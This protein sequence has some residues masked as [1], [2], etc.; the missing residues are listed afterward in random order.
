MEKSYENQIQSWQQEKE[1][2]MRS[3]FGWLSIRG[4][5]WLK[6]GT[7]LFGT[8]PSLPIVL[9]KKTAPAHAGQF[10]LKN[11]QMFLIPNPGIE[12]IVNSQKPT[13]RQLIQ[14]GHDDIRLG[15]LKLE[16]IQRDN[17][18][19]VRV[20]DGKSPLLKK[21][22]RRTWFPIQKKWRLM[23]KLIT[24]DNNQKLVTTNVL[25]DT[26][27]WDKAQ[28][29]VFSHGSQEYRLLSTLE[30]TGYLFIL[31]KDLSSKT[32]TYPAG[33]FLWAKPTPDGSVILDFNKAV[34]PPCAVTSYATCPLPPKENYL[35][36]V[37]SAGEKYAK[38][39]I[40]H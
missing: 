13:N 12:F 16:V 30:D 33:R 20:R 24:Q 7:H 34:N 37:I 23:G 5:H 6:E 39:P 19:G 28:T 4:L 32:H 25:G 17:R 1:K 18:Y 15:Q 9:P 11:G 10:E 26:V 31:F 2:E 27:S 38:K 21:F 14:P 22:P 29:I 3:P 8:D 40:G 36:I 35:P